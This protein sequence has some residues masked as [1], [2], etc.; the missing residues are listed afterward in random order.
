MGVRLVLLAALLTNSLSAIAAKRFSEDQLKQLLTAAQ[1]LHR[2]DDAVVQQLAAVRLANR[3]SGTELQQILALSPG[4]K[5]TQAL[6][7]IADASA[8]LAPPAGQL[9][10]TPA[11]DLAAQ[12]A[13]IAR[14]TDYVT[15]TMHALPN[16]LATR[17]TES[18][19]DTLRGI[20]QAQP[21]RGGLYLLS[22]ACL[23]VGTG[24]KPP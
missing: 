21:E 19:V 12:K 5:S 6:H 18:Y 23:R 8:F 13:I 11:P 15:N 9:P 10:A 14:A 7:A 2:A 24:W 17:V 1:G 20:D 16:F 3:L 22:I 4:P